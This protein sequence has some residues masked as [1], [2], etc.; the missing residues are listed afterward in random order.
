MLF[1][2]LKYL[3][4]S[5]LLFLFNLGACAKGPLL[6]SVAE[7]IAMTSQKTIRSVLKENGPHYQNQ[8][9]YFISFSMAE[10]L[11]KAYLQEAASNHGILVLRGISNNMNLHDFLIKKM[12][13]LLQDPDHPQA[14]YAAIEI[15]PQLFLKYQVTQVPSLVYARDET[16]YWKVS[17]PVTGRWAMALFAK[18]Q[19]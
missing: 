4:I 16:L 8:L 9:Y 14:A 7:K 19:I 15:N 17:G 2:Y 18:N 12:L 1:E 6:S 13:P 5:C 11:I 10:S 3:L